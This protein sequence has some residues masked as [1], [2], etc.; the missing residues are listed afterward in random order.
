MEGQFTK[1]YTRLFL[2]AVVLCHLLLGANY[3]QANSFANMQSQI[4]SQSEN[5]D[6][7]ESTLGRHS[8]QLVE[9]LQHLALVQLQANR[10]DDAETSIDRAIQI[11]R[12]SDGLFSNRQYDLLQLAIEINI[13]RRDWDEVEE[14]LEHL[15][16]L[17]SSKFEGEAEDHLYRFQW[18][19]NT[20]LRGTLDDSAARRGGHIIAATGLIE[21]AVQLAQL[22]PQMDTLTYA[23]LLYSLSHKY[24]IETRGILGG[25]KTSHALRRLYPHR[26]IFESRTDAIA[27]RYRVG[28]EKLVMLRNALVRSSDFDLEAVALAELYIADWNL[29]FNM[30][31][32]IS[33]EYSVAINTLRRA[34]VAE[35]DL[36]RFFA[37]PV[38]LP[39]P[40]LKLNF[41]Q[42][43]ADIVATERPA[44]RSDP[45]DR[46][47][48]A[49]D[50]SMYRLS[51]VERSKYLPGYVQ[52]IST[53][54][55]TSRNLDDWSSLSLSMRIDPNT[56]ATIWS[57]GY[58]SRNYATGTDI[59]V[60]NAPHETTK[61]LNSVVSRVSLISFRPALVNGQARPMTIVLDYVFRNEDSR[62]LM[63]LLSLR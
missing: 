53:S 38:I 34:G 9:P 6:E 15:K 48:A 39:R 58:R 16:W 19:A 46:T 57:S 1:F 60:Q 28:L 59:Q 43:L 22:S 51:F 25:G 21:S 52:E 18:L 26:Q 14:Q 7:L 33:A 2:A 61:L 10:F 55:F 4:S 54:D 56:R 31:D 32:D 24:F 44:T 50:R 29:V 17:V 8:F 36:N 47:L 49:L 3:S 41:N 40:E 35:E 30:T 45:R 27:K 42:A 20:H 5:I 63:S 12:L 37:A 23:Q 13:Q 11:T 62:S